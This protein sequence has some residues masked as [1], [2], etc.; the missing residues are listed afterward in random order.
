MPLENGVGISRFTPIKLRQFQS[1]IEM[2]LAISKA[3]LNRN[4]FYPQKYLYVD[5]TAGPGKYLFN[6]TELT[7]TPIVFLNTVERLA[8]S[9]DAV[10][11]EIDTANFKKLEKNLPSTLN[12][13][14][15][16]IKNED[17]KVTLSKLLS[18]NNKNQ[19]GMIYVDPSNG[20]PDFELLH[21]TNLKMPKM[22][23]LLYLS[24][25]NL[26]RT[27][28]INDAMLSDLIAKIGK[29]NWLVRKPIKGD[30]HQWTFLLGSNCNLFKKYEKIDF[31][32]IDSPEA[33]QFFLKLD[34][35]AK[36]LKIKMQPSLFKE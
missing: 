32:P 25:T 28:G 8:I 31:F 21:E 17:Y 22:E 29:K 1:I 5:V 13:G 9:Y 6:N 24:A 18:K 33:Q 23:V 35:N 30:R 16:N 19:L 26:K 10:F 4:L 34:L 11:L 36:K 20:I 3:V 7:G 2:H 27:Q 12:F 14:E 15:V